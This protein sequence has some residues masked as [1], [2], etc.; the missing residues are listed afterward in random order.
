MAGGAG[1]GDLVLIRH[2][3]WDEVEGVAAYVDVR[4][5]LLNFRHMARNAIVAGAPGT[6]VSVR[7]NARGMGSVGGRWPVA[8][9]TQLIHRLDQVGVVFGSMNIVAIETRHAAAIHDA[10]NEVV[11]LHSILVTRPVGEMHEVRFAEFV[12]L[13][14]PEILQVEPLVETDR[15][16]VILSTNRVAERL[17]LGMAL[18]ARIGRVHKIESCRI[19]D[20]GACRIG[21][22]LAAGTMASLAADIPFGNSLRLDVV[23]HR[24]AS[25][26]E[27]PRGPLH[28]IGR[29]KGD[30]PV[31]I[32]RHKVSAPDLVI[33]VPLRG[34]GEVII[35]DFLEVALLPLRAIN[36]RDVIDLERQQRI[37]F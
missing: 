9:Q 36:E 17:A 16:I 26:T 21:G 3:R 34:K 13:E 22:M 1:V 28:V 27:R 20:I 4:D 31:G 8:G 5:R 32:R 33:H 24:M 11:A 10:L 6:M 14:L 18:D 30:P 35:A 29:I 19:H 12:L 7:F 25:V 37:R 15:P 23:I 2:L